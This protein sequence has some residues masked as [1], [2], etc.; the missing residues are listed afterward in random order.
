M[1]GLPSSV[2]VSPTTH[3]AEKPRTSQRAVVLLLQPATSQPSALTSERSTALV[4]AKRSLDNKGILSDF[5]SELLQS[6]ITTTTSEPAGTHKKDSHLQTA[7]GAKAHGPF[8]TPHVDKST[9]PESATA[10]P[11]KNTTEDVSGYSSPRE[12]AERIQTHPHEAASLP[13]SV[14]KALS[15]ATNCKGEL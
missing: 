8:Q 11:S 4:I 3:S 13:E 1:E 7:P 15:E 6:W 2:R 12:Q 9:E 10:P 5:Y 14:T